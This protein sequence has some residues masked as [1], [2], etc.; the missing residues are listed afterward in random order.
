M[1]AFVSK[2]G[3]RRQTGSCFLEGV[4]RALV[5]KLD[6]NALLFRKDL[7]LGSNDGDNGLKP[8]EVLANG[9]G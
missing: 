2:C 6:P 3:R 7:L 8:P 5:A 4:S 1:G 9:D